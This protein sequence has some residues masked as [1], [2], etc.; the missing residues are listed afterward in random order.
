MIVQTFLLSFVLFRSY[1]LG[2]TMFCM[3]VPRCKCNDFSTMDERT[4]WLFAELWTKIEALFIFSSVRY[5]PKFICFRYVKTGSLIFAENPTHLFD[6]ILKQIQNKIVWKSMCWIPC[7]L[8]HLWLSLFSSHFA[9]NWIKIS[10]HA[11]HWKLKIDILLCILISLHQMNAMWIINVWFPGN[12][13]NVPS[14]L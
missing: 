7:C 10:R 3:D 14:H 9:Q 12:D 5:F 2:C 11:H 6:E 13:W 8:F 1:K 4:I